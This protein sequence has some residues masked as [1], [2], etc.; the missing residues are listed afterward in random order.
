ME[1]THLIKSNIIL[2]IKVEF[3]RKLCGYFFLGKTKT[4]KLK[5]LLRISGAAM[6]IRKKIRRLFYF[7]FCRR[8]GQIRR[9]YN[10]KNFKDM[11][12]ISLILSIN[13]CNESLMYLQY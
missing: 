6:G 11:E 8:K 4:Y 13:V 2:K 3:L 12:T 7:Y 9:H 10:G 1:P 5:N